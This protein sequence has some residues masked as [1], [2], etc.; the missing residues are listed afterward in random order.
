MTK[1][2]AE[3]IRIAKEDMP[4]LQYDVQNAVTPL[5]QQ[6][7]MQ[8]M[9]NIMG[10]MLHHQIRATV[11]ALQGQ[12]A[13]PPAAPA[14]APAPVPVPVARPVQ[15]IAPAVFPR[16]PAYTPPTGDPLGIDLPPPPAVA[17]RQPSTA[18]TSPVAGMPD[19]PVQPGVANV[20][21]TSQGTQVISPT[22]AKT[23]LPPG[24][25]VDAS[26]TTGVPELPP[27][28]EDGENVVLPPGGG[29]TPEVLAALASRINPA[30]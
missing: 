16:I 22:G 17:Q 1:Y 26:A 19:A 24:E 30:G 7:L 15:R 5:S 14:P 20:F 8:K 23:V 11:A 29:M 21:I 13:Q 9:F 10:Y 25:A 18:F 6:P 3:L 27:P 28:P 12:A 4:I 2:L